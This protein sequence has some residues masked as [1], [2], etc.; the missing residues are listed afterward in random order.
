MYKRKSNGLRIDPWGTPDFISAQ[1]D[2]E[3]FIE[4]FAPRSTL[5]YLPLRYDLSKAPN[6]PVIP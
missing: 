1:L 4:L 6:L 2:E 3:L 5:W